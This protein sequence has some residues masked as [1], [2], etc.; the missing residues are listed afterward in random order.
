MDNFINIQTRR[1]KCS[2]SRKKWK[3]N[4]Q[5]ISSNTLTQISHSLRC[6]RQTNKQSIFRNIDTNLIRR[7]H[8]RIRS[9]GLSPLLK[10]PK[11]KTVK[12]NNNHSGKN[13]EIYTR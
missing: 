12:K 5:H 4:S 10:L 3:N 6:N 13:G 11:K 2:F 1:N 8:K 9:Q 7:F